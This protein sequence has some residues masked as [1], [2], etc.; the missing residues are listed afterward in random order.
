MDNRKTDLPRFQ[1]NSKN[2]GNFQKLPSHVTGAI[3]TSGLYPEGSKNY[4]YI[5]N[6]QYEQG[7]CMVITVI[8]N[9]LQS[10]LKD[11]KKFPK[12]LHINTDNCARFFF[13]K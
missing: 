7:S 5:N 6:N 12:Y 2:L 3:V 9:I 10:F 4:F 8:Y 13:L 1:D 11:H